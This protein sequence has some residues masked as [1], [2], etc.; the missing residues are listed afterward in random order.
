MPVSRQKQCI[1]KKEK[2]NRIEQILKAWDGAK[3]AEPPAFFYT[4]L[5]ARMLARQTGGEKE[6]A[7]VSQPEKNWLL[8]PAFVI[9]GLALVL[10]LNVFIFLQNNNN[11]TTTVLPEDESIQTIAAEFN[12]SDNILEEIN[13]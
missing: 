1:M 7:S 13:Q 12:L 10:I 6:N 9:A 5:R 8:R 4:R 2:Q 11:S 3:K